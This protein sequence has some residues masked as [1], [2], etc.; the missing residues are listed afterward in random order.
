VSDIFI[1]YASEDRDRAKVLA[2]ALESEGWSV[3]WDRMIPFGRPFDDVIQENIDAAK[4]VLVLWTEHS[5]ASKWV[6]S[7]ATEAEERNTLVPVLLGTQVD[8][9]LA[10][11][12]LQA[13]DLSAWEP[14]VAHPE[15]DKLLDQIRSLIAGTG[16][17]APSSEIKRKARPI[18]RPAAVNRRARLV[19]LGFVV[20]PPLL[21]VIGAAVLMNWQIPT[22]IEMTLE[23]DRVSFSIAGNEAAPILERAVS[24]K[25]L[26][27]EQLARVELTTASLKPTDPAGA[28][29]RQTQLSLQAQPL[30]RMSIEID[31]ADAGTAGRL[32]ELAADPAS[33]VV[34]E[35]RESSD[36]TLTLHIDGQVV[37]PAVLPGEN[38]LLTVSN[39]T[40][41]SPA[42]LPRAPRLRMAAQRS[43]ANPL[44]SVRS[45][46]SGATLV[47][48][49]SKAF[50]LLADG[51]APVD[52]LELLKQSSTG[53]YDSALA[54]PGRISYPG[55]GK[56]EVKVGAH[57]LL[58]VEGLRNAMLSAMTVEPDSRTLKLVF[59]GTVQRINARQGAEPAQDL[60]LSWFDRLWYGSRT[61]LLFSI[62]VWAA[63]VALGA[64]KLFRD[65]K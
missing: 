1:S 60:R 9:P 62:G 51:G 4:C 17:Q 61:A 38:V 57:S 40:V 23:V 53:S 47:L 8:I 44:M 10:F 32:S 41:V 6:R 13:A 34:M 46:P 48:A 43:E 29:F 5:T 65:A 58:R 54:G 21:A 28:A 2:H 64:Y 45:V 56:D 18:A 50:Q 7:E 37:E 52:R 19:L 14:G 63:S 30:D 55:V 15:Y 11:K 31:G 22:R 3:W 27:L 20:L 12:L 26:T 35:M 49:P 16:A 59:R 39:A 36:A 42:G 24:F 25:R 33:T